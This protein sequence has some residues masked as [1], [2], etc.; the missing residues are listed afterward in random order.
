MDPDIRFPEC[1]KQYGCDVEYHRADLSADLVRAALERAADSVPLGV[2]G[3]SALNAIA[4]DAA[5]NAIRAIAND[6]EAVAAIVAS[7]VKQ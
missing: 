1:E 5:E 6:P 2:N 4:L 7:V 3:M